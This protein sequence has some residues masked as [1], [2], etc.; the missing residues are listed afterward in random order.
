[1][2]FVH[3]K[4]VAARLLDALENG[5]LPIE[6]I[7]PL[8]E[9]A[10]P[11]LLHLIIGW[12]RA[13]YAGHSA[14]EGVFGRVVDICR[15]PSVAKLAKEGESDSIASWFKETYDFRDLQADEF[16]ELVVEKL[17]G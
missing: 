10:D 7:K 14:A 9:E 12:L 2:E 15:Y 11:A 13:N 8:A 5:S 3:E 17:E 1:L 4:R 16:I 6:D